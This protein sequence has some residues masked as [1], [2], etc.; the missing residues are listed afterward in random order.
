[1]TLTE[2]KAAKQT[3]PIWILIYRVFIKQKQQQNMNEKDFKSIKID[4]IIEAARFR[5]FCFLKTLLCVAF[6]H[7][8]NL[9]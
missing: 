1:M 5:I 6:L 8:N 7:Q 4:V 2:A 3:L 9:E